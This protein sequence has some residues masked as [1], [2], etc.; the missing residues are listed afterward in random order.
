M[1]VC[2]CVNNN[3]NSLHLYSAFL[4]TQRALHSKGES[5]HPPPVC[6]IRLD[7]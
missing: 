2:V 7:D 3:N 4:G 5:P 6:S 1:C